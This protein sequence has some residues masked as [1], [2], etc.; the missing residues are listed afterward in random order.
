VYRSTY[1]SEFLEISVGQVLDI[2]L[3]NTT[4]DERLLDGAISVIAEGKLA[5]QEVVSKDY[6]IAWLRGANRTDC[7]FEISHIFFSFRVQVQ[8]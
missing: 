4:H 2:P 3:G 7:N 5:F 1:C 6:K 8:I